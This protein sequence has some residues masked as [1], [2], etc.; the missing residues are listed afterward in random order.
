M[1]AATAGYGDLQAASQRNAARAAA[2]E[3]RELALRTRRVERMEAAE[4]KRSSGGMSVAEAAFPQTEPLTT[5]QRRLF[6]MADRNRDAAEIRGDLENRPFVDPTVAANQRG[7]EAKAAIEADAEAAKNKE[8]AEATKS[9]ESFKFGIMT[10]SAALRAFDAALAQ[11]NALRAGGASDISS[12]EQRLGGALATMGA[13]AGKQERVLQTLRAG[14]TGA[15]TPEDYVSQWEAAAQGSQGGLL[16]A[17]G[18]SQAED[19]I[20]QAVSGRMPSRQ[21]R[22][23]LSRGPLPDAQLAIGAIG[24][25]QQGARTRGAAIWSSGI[26]QEKLRAQLASEAQG[27][28]AAE[29]AQSF[30]NQDVANPVTS[31]LDRLLGWRSIFSSAIQGARNEGPVEVRVSTP[32]VPASSQGTSGSIQ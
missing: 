31:A 14:G 5:D 18:L 1:A 7:D 26:A 25:S 6:R 24:S 23:I 19:V 32:A 20:G 22:E 17:A 12:L 4:N 11:T 15:L 30:E 3:E 8:T 2:L 16:G 13:D 9:L 10:V 27:R 29:V 21:V 28:T